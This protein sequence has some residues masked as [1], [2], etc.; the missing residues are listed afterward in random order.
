MRLIEA[1]V[2]M[3]ATC[4][5]ACSPDTWDSAKPLE[6]PQ[7]GYPCGTA[8]HVCAVQKTCCRDGTVCGGEPYVLNCPAGS[9]CDEGDV[10]F[11]G[12]RDA[13]ARMTPQRPQL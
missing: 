2:V 4:G 8:W 3:L 5:T 12:A 13:G 10:V 6:A 1:F 11:G 9:C 7:P